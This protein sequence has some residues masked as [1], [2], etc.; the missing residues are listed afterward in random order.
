[1]GVELFWGECLSTGHNSM[2]VTKT[3]E[4][5]TLMDE[6]CGTRITSQ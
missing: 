5:H 2:N 3:T 1:M 4:P 6:L